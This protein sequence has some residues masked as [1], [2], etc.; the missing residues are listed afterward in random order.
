MPVC[1]QIS[2]YSF[3]NKITNKLFTYRSHMHNHLNVFKHAESNCYCN[4]TIL[5]TFLLCETNCC[6]VTTNYTYTCTCG[7]KFNNND[8][9]THFFRKIYL[10][11]FIRKGLWKGYER[12]MCKRWVGDWKN[13]NILTPVPLSLAALLS[14]SAGLLNRG[15]WGHITLCWVL[16]LST[17]SYTQLT[18]SN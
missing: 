11:H 8:E 7:N 6:I 10:S 2:S 16:V 4:T 18:D 12:V 9:R 14:R 5:Y 13:C 17:A 3:E 1:K 15:S